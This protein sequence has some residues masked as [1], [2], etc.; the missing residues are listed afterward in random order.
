[1]GSPERGPV[2]LAIVSDFELVIAGVKGMLSAHGDRV[3]VVPLPAQVSM[4]TDVDVVLWDPSVRPAG[5]GVELLKLAGRSATLVAFDWTAESAS[6]D[7]ERPEPVTGHLSK[8]LTAWELVE[9]VEAV[10][11]HRDVGGRAE[12]GHWPGEHGLTRREAEVLALIAQGLSNQEIADAVYLSINSV[13]SHIRTAYRKLG[14]TRR[15]QAVGWVLQ[16]GS[17]SGR[18]LGRR[19]SDAEPAGGHDRAYLS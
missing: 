2:R 3:V 4:S 17:A 19:P 9:A 15:S 1:M 8:S 14:V 5:G 7:P 6:V 16:D 13:K 10:R 18:K 12:S 11:D